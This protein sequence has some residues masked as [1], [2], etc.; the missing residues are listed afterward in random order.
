M[1]VALF[2][3][4]TKCIMQQFGE[5]SKWISK[6]KHV[7]VAIPMWIGVPGYRDRCR[8]TSSMIH[9]FRSHRNKCETINS[10]FAFIIGSWW[11][12]QMETFSAL[13]AMCAGNS[14]V[15]GEFPAQ[16]PVTRSFY[17][18][19]DL[20][21]NKRLS[22]QWRGWSFETPLRLLW[23]HCNVSVGCQYSFVHNDCSRSATW[24]VSRGML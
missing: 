2:R 5:I 18:F 22:K 6:A 23:R 9:R 24:H 1:R 3:T 17:V 15:T 10:L 21:L 20:P 12:H 4:F 7:S 14:P 19:F 8:V 11:R 13:L 16:R